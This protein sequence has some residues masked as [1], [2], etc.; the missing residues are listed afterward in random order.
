[1]SAKDI[2]NLLSN[3]KTEF[4]DLKS[5]TNSLI[6]KYESL[7][8]QLKKQKKSSF[9]CS[10]CDNKFSNVKELQNHKKETSACQG[11]FECDECEKT[12]KTEKQLS[13]HMK[14]HEKFA[15]EECDSEYNYEGLLEKH[16]DAVHGSMKIYCHYWNNEKECPYDDQC[17]FAHEDSPECKFRK[18]CERILCMFQHEEND[19]DNDD[20]SKNENSDEDDDDE[21]DDD[22]GDDVSDKN[23]VNVSDLEPI[24]KK[25]EDAMEKV[26]TLLQKQ[27]SALKCDLCDFEAKNSN[28]LT[29]HKK[30]KHTDNSK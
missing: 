13:V 28:G 4:V 30:A 19:D 5:K 24:L 10:K 16:V 12:F 27:L 15:C 9:K 22:N 2:E 25:V 23:L 18:G 3:L 1:M 29:M 20:E 11:N 8:K 17:I 21:S 6:K 7:E 14:K 26:N